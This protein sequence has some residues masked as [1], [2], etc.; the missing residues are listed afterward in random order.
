MVE[1]GK[2]RRPSMVRHVVVR[3]VAKPIDLSL[4]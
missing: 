4:S 1:M 2:M 3:S